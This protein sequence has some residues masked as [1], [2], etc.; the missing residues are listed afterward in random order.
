VSVTVKQNPNRVVY[1]ANTTV[2]DVRVEL[3]SEKVISRYLNLFRSIAHKPP[4]PLL[5]AEGQK[6]DPDTGDFVRGFVTPTKAGAKV[7]KQASKRSPARLIRGRFYYYQYTAENRQA[8]KGDLQRGDKHFNAEEHDHPSIPLPALP[9]SIVEGKYY[10]VAEVTFSWK[11]DNAMLTWLALVELETGAILHIEPLSSGLTG[12][13]FKQDPITSTG[14]PTRTANLDNA[15][16]N[17][18]RTDETLNNLDAPDAGVQHL[19]GSHV[20]IVDVDGRTEAAPTKAAGVNFD[21]NVRTNDFAAVSAY[22]HADDFF[23]TVESLGFD[24]ATYFPNTSFP[25]DIDHA[26]MFDVNA[27][28]TGN[29]IGGI[30]HSGYGYGDDTNMTD[31]TIGRAGD[32]WVHWHEIGGHGVLYG[33][34]DSANFGF[35][36][37]AGDGLAAIKNDPTSQLRELGNIERFRYAPFRYHPLDRWFNRDVT[38]GWGWDGSQDLGGYNSEQILATSNFRWY[39]SIGGDSTSLS[40]R[41]FASRMASYLI[42]RAISTLTPETNPNHVQGFCDALMAVDL[43]D[44]TSEGISGGAYNKVIRWAF[45]KQGLFQPTGAAMPVTSAGAPPE[46]DVYIN[47]GRNGEYEYQAV[48]WHNISMWNRNMPDGIEGHLD[49]I[50]SATNYMYVKVKNRGS[51]NAINVNVRGYHCLPGAGLTWPND[52]TEMSPAGGL[53][54]P[55]IAANNGEEIIVGPFEWVPN[56]NIYGH[57]CTLMILSTDGDPSNVDNFTLGDT[58]AEWRL[59][60]NDNNIGQR[61]VHILPGGGGETALIDSL[62][63]HVF[64]AGNPFRVKTLM[65]LKVD[66]P[67]FLTELGWKLQFKDVKNQFELKPGEKRKIVIELI[68]GRNFTAEQARN[69]YDRDIMVSLYGEDMLLG[70]MTYR[71]DPDKKEPGYVPGKK[72]RCTD[73]AQDLLDCLHLSGGKVKKVSVKKVSLDIELNNGDCNC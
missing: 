9:K 71:I 33:H 18:F 38:T 55:S 49:A 65:E 45:E 59:V 73:K 1:A 60:P 47:D 50:P 22:F 26:D 72:D 42:L 32:N 29:G 56:E 34:V 24:L 6:D 39:R 3:P 43:L 27:H 19:S 17:P 48:H 62:H 46:I 44:W 54:V 52:F 36:H 57:D 67:K 40:R 16:L 69:A 51:Q 15:T 11:V 13:V 5:S 12:K 20:H 53:N 30:D 8:A 68:K 7:D 10:L 25:L 64:W 37:S 35:A 61:N 4:V 23:A 63:D 21:F 28:C 70:G 41:Q 14:D 31:P 66:M 58:V 2:Q